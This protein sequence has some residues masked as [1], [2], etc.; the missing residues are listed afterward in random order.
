MKKSLLLIVAFATLCLAD[1]Y[2]QTNADSAGSLLM[3]SP[4]KRRLYTGNGLDFAMLSTAF[5]SKPG[6]GTELTVPR[7]TAVINL[8]FTFHYDLNDKLGLISGLGIRN[9]GF[10]EKANGFTVKRRV[11]SLGIPLG[12]KVGDL[13][14]R[15][16]VFGGAGIDLPFH[17]KEKGFKNRKDK[18]KHSEWFGDQTPRV[19]PFVFVGHSWDPGITLKFQYY[20]GNFVNPDYAQKMLTEEYEYPFSGHKVNLLLLSLGID[21]QYGKYKLHEREYQESKKKRDQNKLM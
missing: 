19:M 18:G 20:P 9:M 7:F 17:Y 4:V 13:R 6:S 14:N 1:I 11:L 12:I 16:F 8:G 15:N 2:A 10:I 5:V 21:I 3:E